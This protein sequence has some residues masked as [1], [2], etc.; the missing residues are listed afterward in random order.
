M[1]RELA[2]ALALAAVVALLVTTASPAAASVAP[3]SVSW[4]AVLAGPTNVS[5]GAP[6][7]VEVSGPPNGTF[8]VSLMGQPP[9]TSDVIYSH[10]YIEPNVSK[11]ATLGASVTVA[12]PTYGL[13]YGPYSVDVSNT[14]LGFE[15]ASFGVALVQGVN[16]TF[17]WQLYNIT[18]ARQQSLSG[19]VAALH[20]Q[21]A[22]YQ[23]DVDGFFY[24]L[25]AVLIGMPLS[26]YLYILS[27]EGYRPAE[28][29][30]QWLGS[31]WHVAFTRPGTSD[32]WDPLRS[33]P[34]TP[35]A[36]PERVFV[37]TGFPRCGAC[38]IP[39]KHAEAIE[40][41]GKEHGLAPAIAETRLKRSLG[42]QRRIEEARNEAG[43]A[44]RIV[45]R[46]V[47]ETIDADAYLRLA[48]EGGG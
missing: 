8:N 40:H 2:A 11:N 31:G 9:L 35:Q 17:L 3:D 37:I 38:L 30:F 26:F 32:P 18:L 12:I 46:A 45:K 13:A 10:S 47:R 6:I 48:S 29:L 23:A 42:A 36:N 34:T 7:A 43:P 22:G 44:R 5:L 19:E 1:L 33:P 28:R 24:A 4:A 15:F 25:M 21:I 27:R 41:A 39:M 14:S 20:A 16:G